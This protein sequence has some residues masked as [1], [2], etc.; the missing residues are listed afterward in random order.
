[1]PAVFTPKCDSRPI[2]FENAAFIKGFLANHFL[3]IP[4][5]FWTPHRKDE[6]NQ[7]KNTDRN[8][9]DILHLLKF[10]LQLTLKANNILQESPPTLC[11]S[12]VG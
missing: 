3:A 10:S 5:T 4:F 1:V 2:R 7:Y 8:G 6:K 12:G 11:E 9:Y